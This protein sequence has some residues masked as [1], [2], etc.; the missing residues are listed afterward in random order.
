MVI[1]K[2]LAASTCGVAVAVAEPSVAVTVW[3]PGIAAVHAARVL[4]R[5]RV[6]PEVDGTGGDVEGAA[7]RIRAET[8]GARGELVDGPHFVDLQVVE[9]GDPIHRGDRAASAEDRS[10]GPTREGQGH[11]D[12]LVGHQHPGGVEYLH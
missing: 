4:E 8:G 11:V 10:P 5:A 2:A 1:R 12:R 3:S 6:M 9:G 7:H